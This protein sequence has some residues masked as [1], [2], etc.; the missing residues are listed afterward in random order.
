MLLAF[1]TMKAL[2]ELDIRTS[3][4]NCTKGEAGRLPLP[5]DLADRP[6]GDLDFLGWQDLSAPDRSY[7]VTEQAGKLV[8]VVMR[9]A[10]QKRG[11]LHSAMCSRCVTSH[12]GNGVSLMTG[13][14]AGPA[15]RQGN[16][17][18]V[19]ICTDLACSLYI[20]GKKTPLTGGRL[21]ES[22]TVEE[23]ID[24]MTGKLSNFLDKILT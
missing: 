24:R 10:T 7:L 1:A 2:T 8:G 15:G 13:R 14:K 22:L 6:W 5:R 18:G 16:S 17:V 4:V 12:P 21:E 9:I 23:Q 20:R 3:F 11:L 19:Y